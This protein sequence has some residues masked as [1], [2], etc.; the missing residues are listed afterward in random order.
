V[1]ASGV[2]E[3]TAAAVRKYYPDGE[4]LVGTVPFTRESLALVT[5]ED[6]V[7][8]SKLVDV[9]VNAII[10]ADEQGIT[11]ETYLDMPRTNLFQSLLGNDAMFRNIIRAV[12]NYQEIWNRHTNPQGG[13]LRGGRNLLNAYPVGPKLITVHTWNKRP[14]TS[15]N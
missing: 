9:V 4:Y 5:K 15:E 7:V 3:R 14:P 6:D 2:V 13:L 12:G 11:Q 1:Y 8:F 10:Y